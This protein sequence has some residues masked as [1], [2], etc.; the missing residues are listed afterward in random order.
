MQM[1]KKAERI[2]WA[3]TATV[4]VLLAAGCGG[5]GGGGGDSR[6]SFDASAL[7][8]NEANN[9]ITQTYSDLNTRAGLLLT[10]V[11]ALADGDATEAELDAAQAAWRNTRVPWETSEGFLFGPV[12]ALGVD[13]AIDSWPLNTPDLKA[14]LAANPNT[15]QQD[16]ENAGDD[17]R[18]FHAMEWL[19]FGLDDDGQDN[20][21]MAVA[22]LINQT[23]AINYLVALAQAFQAQTQLLADSWTT[24]FNGNGAYADDVAN[25]GPGQLFASQSAVVEELVNGVIG[26]ASEVGAAKI[27]DPFGTSIGQADTSQVESQYSWNSL[28]DFHNNIQSVLNVYTGKRGFDPD[29]DTVSAGLNGLYAF[30]AAHDQALAQRVY[31]EIIA[32][33]SRIALIKGDGDDSSTEITGDAKPFR[34]QILNEAGRALIEDAIDAVLMLAT[35]L[36][37]EVLPLVANTDFAG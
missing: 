20:N 26:I 13:P 37:T 11:Q 6:V 23:G 34:E 5:G 32:A 3:S 30:V 28:T 16:I 9:V 15:T 36:E 22:D 33:Q 19:L 31:D 8:A 14:Y 29:T 7:I 24:D 27:A 17:L 25:P 18:G 12:D 4:G 35:T 2:L 1:M 10:A 21:D